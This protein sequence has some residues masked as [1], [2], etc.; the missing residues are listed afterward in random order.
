MK[1]NIYTLIAALI[2]TFVAYAV[3]ETS[4]VE[5][6]ELDINQNISFWNTTSHVNPTVSQALAALADV[7]VAISDEKDCGD[8]LSE[9]SFD[10]RSVYDT[11][12]SESI[13]FTSEPPGLSV[14]IR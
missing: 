4:I 7:A 2:A 6:R 14:I 13:R 12:S 1:L 10:A 5:F 11:V 9:N 8:Y 3:E